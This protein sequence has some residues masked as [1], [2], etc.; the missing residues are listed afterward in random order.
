MAY[1]IENV[2][3]PPG[4]SD[5]RL[6][7]MLLGIA[8]GDALGNTTESIN[9]AQRREEYGEIRDYLPNE[10]ANGRKVG[11]PSDD[12]QLTFWTI[13]SLLERGHIDPANLIDRFAEEQIFNVG[14]AVERAV[15]AY[16]YGAP[17][18]EA[19]EPSAGNGA[20]MR[21]APV[22]LPHLPTGDRELWEDVV[23][24]TMIT[25]D[26]EMA[27][28][29]SVGFTGLLY[30]VLG[31][32]GE[33]STGEWWIDAFIKYARPVETGREYPTRSPEI[34][35]QGSL[36][37]LLDRHVRRAVGGFISIVDACNSWYSGA[38]LLETVPSALLILARCGD[39]PER[40]LIRA[41]NDTRDSDTV[42]S[43]VGA[44]V[45]ALHGESAF[46][47]RWIENL[48]GRT[49][50]DDDGRVMELIDEAVEE[51]GL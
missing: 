5:E 49:R 21:I 15:E 25:H 29:A 7:G 1:D 12:T 39:D 2:P 40:A 38:Y 17:W 32:G 6:R 35:F 9:P 42:A 34:S 46:P 22:L 33:Q 26:D 36:C 47:Q 43:V 16:E 14:H 41:V 24:A 51:F 31:T 3:T 4:P 30:E 23:F 10:H 11:V 50:A 20:L 27:V 8:I 19:G 44:A 45:G 37:D 48:T 18:N 13:E 28:A